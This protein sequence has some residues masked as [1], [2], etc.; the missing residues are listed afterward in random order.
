MNI[1]AS[2]HVL[3]DPRLS[4]EGISPLDVQRALLNLLEDSA[5]EKSHLAD[6]QSAVINILEDFD[7]QREAAEIGRIHV[8][9]ANSALES[10]SYS[11]AHDLRAPLRAIDGFSRILIEDH[12]QDLN[13]EGRRLLDIVVANVGAMGKLI[14]GLLAFSRLGRSELFI[15]DTDMTELVR[16]VD[17]DLRSPLEPTREIDVEIEPL[18]RAR[19]DPVLVRQVWINLLSNSIKFTEE[20]TRAHVTVRRQEIDHET[21]YSIGDDGVGFDMQYADKL[22]GVFQRLHSVAEF[23]GTGIGL[24]IV[25]RIVERHGGRIWA[26]SGEGTTTFSFTLSRPGSK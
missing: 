23:E 24:A 15:V 5:D 16:G 6:M 19:C 18:G 20:R 25:R 13:S 10:F 26:T 8:Q 4:E 14:D 17:A 1:S 22:F 9:Q 21:I 11:V 12:G 3:S 7:I 2:T